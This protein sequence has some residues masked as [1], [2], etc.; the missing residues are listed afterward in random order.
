[1][2]GNFSTSSVSLIHSKLFL[3]NTITSRE[4]SRLSSVYLELKK[5]LSLCIGSSFCWRPFWAR[6]KCYTVESGLTV[7]NAR[8]YL[9][10]LIIVI[11]FYYFFL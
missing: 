9:L 8:N 1:M 6:G 3:S 5:V 11:N 2:L 4:K 7:L 10:I